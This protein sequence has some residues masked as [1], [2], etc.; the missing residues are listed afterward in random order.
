MSGRAALALLFCASLAGP[1]FG[2]VN[3]QWKFK[4]G[5]KFYLEE[6][7]TGETAVTVLGQKNIEKHTQ[8]RLS[9]FVVKSVSADGY[10]MEQRIESWKMQTV[11][12]FPGAM[13]DGGKFLDHLCK[14]AVFLVKI[15]KAGVITKFE[16]HDKLL[17]KIAEAN[18]PEAE[19]FKLMATEDVLRSPLVMA[20][21]LLPEKMVNKGEKWRKVSDVTI[22]ALGKFTFTTDFT[23]DGK[24]TGDTITSKG[25]IAY[26][27]GKGDLGMGVKLV[28]I[29]LK[30]NE[31]TGKVVFDNDKGRLVSREMTMPLTGTLTI[32]TQGQ[33]LDLQLDSTETRTI[34]LHAKKPES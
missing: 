24:G 14:D 31:H 26:V 2:Q 13:E 19:Q 12:G 17:K 5:D 1:A 15:T 18:T 16:G 10:V 29:D 3:L 9:S 25:T 11:G 4:E 23:L 33:M 27:A 32:E 21:D 6:K 8:Q 20:F 28:K 7:L 34:R 30:K 22:A